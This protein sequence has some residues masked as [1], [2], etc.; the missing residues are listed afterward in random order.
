M[1]DRIV[2][3]KR[4]KINKNYGKTAYFTTKNAVITTFC[5]KFAEN[6]RIFAKILLSITDRKRQEGEIDKTYRQLDRMEPDGSVHSAA[7]HDPYPSLSEI[8]RRKG[9]RCRIRATGHEGEH[10]QHRPRIPESHHH[11]RRYALRPAEPPHAPRLANVC[12][13]RPSGTRRR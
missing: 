8:P 13:N 11:K 9:G 12:Q 6:L 3:L 7:Y 5:C 4:G 2:A 1:F 10:R